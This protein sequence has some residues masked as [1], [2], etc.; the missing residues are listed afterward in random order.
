[1]DDDGLCN[2]MDSDADG[3]TVLNVGPNADSNDLNA[4]VCKDQDN[5]TCDDCALTGLPDTWNDGDDYDTDGKCNSGDL[6]DD[7]DGY[8]DADEVACG[9]DALD[10]SDLPPDHDQDFKC[11]AVDPDDDNDTVIDG[12]DSYPFDRTLCRDLDAD[13]CDDCAVIF[14]PSTTNDGTDSDADGQC[15]LSDLDDDNDGF[16]DIHEATCLSNPLVNQGNLPVDHDDDGLCDNGVDSD[17]DDDGFS[18]VD[19]LACFSNDA[20]AV[21]DDTRMPTDTVMLMVNVIFQI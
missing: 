13:N 1:L 11:N 18:D 9:S 20:T 19:E 16:S 17:D 21:T 10:V 2:A 12:N 8:K 3:D 15:N 7:G 5:D 6:D 14:K 4:M